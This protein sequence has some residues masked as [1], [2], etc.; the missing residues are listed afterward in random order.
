MT[1]FNVI[2]EAAMVQARRAA[3]RAGRPGILSEDPDFCAA[4]RL[5][6]AQPKV[7]RST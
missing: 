4:V 2:E 7:N 5:A 3:G 1:A 6:A